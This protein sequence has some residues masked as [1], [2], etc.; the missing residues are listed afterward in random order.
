[1][2]RRLLA[3]TALVAVSGAAAGAA[4]LSA[5]AGSARVAPTATAVALEITLPGRTTLRLGAAVAGAP[6]RQSRDLAAPG[7]ASLA[8]IAGAAAVAS[9]GPDAVGGAIEADGISLLDGE[10]TVRALTLHEAHGAASAAGAPAAGPTLAIVALTVLGARIPA[11]AGG[12][13]PVGDWGVLEVGARTPASRKRA[14]SLAA[15]RLQLVAPH[16]GVPAGT[17]VSIGVVKAAGAPSA[18]RAPAA[19]ISLRV[20]GAAAL[21]RVAVPVTP[22]R[23]AFPLARSTPVTDTFGAA[24]AGVVWHHGIDLFAPR[25]TAVVAVSDSTVFELGWNPRGGQRLWLRD[26]AGNAFYYAHLDAYAPGLRNGSRVRAGEPLGLVGNTGDAERTPSHLHFEIH[27]AA[28]A[29]VGYDGA[30]DPSTILAAWQRGSDAV[31]VMAAPP[32]PVRRTVAA[33]PAA[34]LLEA[35]VTGAKP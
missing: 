30:I 27:P 14:G 24:R 3:A 5:T 7:N 9:T 6:V 10:I 25:G 22:G 12:R 35:D 29:A 2:R 20:A 26:A 34:Y 16:R 8:R 21:A 23:H 4:T 33:R 11:R 13:I 32:A 1:M 28:L 17:V 31:P 15:L 19:R 18:T